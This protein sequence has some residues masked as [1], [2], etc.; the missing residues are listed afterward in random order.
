LWLPA[1]SPRYPNDGIGFEALERAR[2]G[3]RLGLLS[4]EKRAQL[5]G[6]TLAIKSAPERGTV[7][8]AQAR[9]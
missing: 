5:A 8:P 4:T 3:G 7:I 1:R 9:G 6:G 2:L